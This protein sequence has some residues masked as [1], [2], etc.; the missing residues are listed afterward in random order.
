MTEITRGCHTCVLESDP[1]LLICNNDYLNIYL[2]CPNWH[3][4]DKYVI[5][6]QEDRENSD[7][8]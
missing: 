5:S 8:E 6:Q 4:K 3:P 1:P 7:I 2:Y